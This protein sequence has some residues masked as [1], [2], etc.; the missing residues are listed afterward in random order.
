MHGNISRLLEIMARL[1]DPK[2]GC[3]WDV[4]QSFETIVPYTIE[5]AYEVAD[6]IQNGDMAALK[7]ELGDLLL[8]VVFHARIAEESGCFDFFDVVEGI[9]DKMVRRHPHVFGED[10]IESTEAQRAN[11]ER[12]KAEERQAKARAEGRPVSAL[13]GVP[14]A[15]PALARAEKLGKRAARAGFD[16]PDAAGVVAKLEEEIAELRAEISAGSP[17]ARTADEIGDLLFTLAN[18]ARHLGIDPENALRHANAKFER[19]F[20]AM[21]ESFA[22]DGTNIAAATPEERERRW[23]AVK[24]RTEAA[25]E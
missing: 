18:L 5:E 23:Q 8:Q 25:A 1:R 21:E 3:P 10:K 20:R 7:E 22:T 19:R 15:L 2:T 4:E 13:D 14:L 16:W 6:A 11:W 24:R 12:H 9:I 17:P